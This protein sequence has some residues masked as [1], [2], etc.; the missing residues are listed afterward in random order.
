MTM[1]WLVLPRAGTAGTPA[2]CAGFSMTVQEEPSRSCAVFAARAIWLNPAGYEVDDSF[3]MYQTARDEDRWLG[4]DKLMHFGVS[5]MLTL[6]T[7]YFLVHRM[8]LPNDRAWPVSAGTALAFGLFKELADSQREHRPLFSW[9]DMAA[10]AAGVGAAV[11]V[12]RF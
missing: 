10:N 2:E 12:I 7:Q 6:S 3:Q 11:V 4:S 1:A 8:D 9:R 5:F